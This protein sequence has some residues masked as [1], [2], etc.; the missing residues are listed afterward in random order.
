MALILKSPAFAEGERIPVKYTCDGLNISP[1]LYWEGVPSATQSFAL[2]MDDP[3]APGGIWD[4]W[5]VFNISPETRKLA[6]NLKTAPEGVYYGKNSWG[7]SS[8]GGPCPPD[9]EHRYF[10]KIYALDTQLNLGSQI[11]KLKLEAAIRE[12]ILD[13]GVLMAR[14]RR[15]S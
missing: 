5:L 2:V 9:G 13:T 8:Y 4:H 7:N 12:H 1:P 14:Y 11:N 6:E 3:D 15:I 10:F